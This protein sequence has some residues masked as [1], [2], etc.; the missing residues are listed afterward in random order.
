[1]DTKILL[2]TTR[3]LQGE[4]TQN[5]RALYVAFENFTIKLLFIYNGEITDN[6][7]DN[8]AY[9]SSLIIVDFNE[10]KIDEKAIRIDYPKSFMLSKKYVLVYESQENIASNLDKI[11][12]DLD[13][14]K[15]DKD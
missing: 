4:I 8:I 5:V 13:K 3:A 9:I 15:L 7:Q 12:V 14:L 1:M 2:S 10:Y 11:F 6:D